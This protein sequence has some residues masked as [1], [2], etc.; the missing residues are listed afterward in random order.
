[1]LDKDVVCPSLF[2]AVVILLDKDEVFGLDKDKVWP[3]LARTL[4]LHA[5]ALP[6]A[7]AGRRDDVLEACALALHPVTRAPVTQVI[8][9][10]LSLTGHA[11][12]I[13]WGI[14]SFSITNYHYYYHCH[15][16]Y[17]CFVIIIKINLLLS[18]SLS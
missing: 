13:T 8:T 3:V 16:Y 6:L 12:L 2:R 1:M 7:V 10:G 14:E 15:R 5:H 11:H 4:V 18:V 17:Y 9:H